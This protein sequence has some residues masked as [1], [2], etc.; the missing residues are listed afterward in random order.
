M[1]CQCNY[2]YSFLYLYI[3][4][5]KRLQH[6]TR[7]IAQ[8][9]GVLAVQAKD[10]SSHPTTYIKTLECSCVPVTPVLLVAETGGLLG[11]PSHQSSWGSTE[12]PCI[13]GIRKW[14]NRTPDVLL[15]HLG[16]RSAHTN[17]SKSTLHTVTREKKKNHKIKFYHKHAHVAKELQVFSAHNSKP[18]NYQSP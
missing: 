5:S 2:L 8:W 7:K 10:L 9:L 4:I 15:Q 14:Q 11:P 6:G 18:T 13:K 3:Y 1:N 16:R 17:M 12:R